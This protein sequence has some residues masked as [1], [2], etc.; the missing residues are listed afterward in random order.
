MRSLEPG[1]KGVATRV[2]TSDLTAIAMG[3]GDVPVLA[4][5]A[6]LAL[7][8]E[9]CVNCVREFLPE[10]ST[11]VGTW[12]TLDHIAPSVVGATVTATTTLIEVEG[13]T[14]SFKCEVTD[15]GRIVA[16]AEHKRSIVDRDKFLS[17]LKQ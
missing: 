4:T 1:I 14:L 17:R 8:E 11:S 16:R 10:G 9:A 2:V 6:V 12:A 15:E 5:P 13:R 7:I 3:S